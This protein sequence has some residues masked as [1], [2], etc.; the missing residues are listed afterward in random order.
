MKK[1][2]SFFGK[3]NDLFVE[4]NDRAKQYALE[5]GLDYEWV[6]Q[7]PFSEQSVISA[8]QQAD[9]GIIDIEPY[10]ENIFPYVC[11]SA[12]LLIRFG[13]G[14][15]KVDLKSASRHGIAVARTTG[16]NTSAVAEMAVTLMLCAKRE[17]SYNQA[18]TPTG[19]WSSRSLTNE[20]IG[21]TVGIVGFG[22]VGQAVARLAKG[23]GCRIL[24][25]NPRP[26]QQIVEEI[27]AEQV[28]L[29]KLFAESDAITLHS[30]YNES[31][32][33]M[34][35]KSLLDLMKPSAVLVNTARG[36]L[37]D[38]DDLYDTLKSHRIRGAALDVFS[39]EPLSP[40]SKF[41]DLDNIILTPHVASQ[42]LESLWNIYS[43]AIDIAADFFEGKSEKHI[44]N[45]DYNKKTETRIV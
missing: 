20:L 41:F 34:V 35:N 1:V 26:K 13:V 27:G 8:L 38:D 7:D 40:D 24:V 11:G 16:A 17:I 21:G 31:S 12:K 14:Y 2:V 19:D 15:D 33:H 23:L 43:M 5:K 4:L 45:P 36:A 10:G 39:Q 22:S 6:L 28:S 32:H 25:Y 30:A 18:V 3:K 9:A 44:L 42:T 29:E 37:I